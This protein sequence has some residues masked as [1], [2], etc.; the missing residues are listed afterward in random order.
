[1]KTVVWKPGSMARNFGFCMSAFDL[2]M[3]VSKI[4]LVFWQSGCP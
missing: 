1:M 3:N 2:T 4:L